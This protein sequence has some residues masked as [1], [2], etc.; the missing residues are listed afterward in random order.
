MILKDN[1]LYREW[2][3]PRVKQPVLQLVIPPSMKEDL[4]SQL[5]KQRWSGH[6]GIKRTLGRM[7]RCVYWAGYKADIHRLCR[8]CPECLRCKSP[9]KKPRHPLKKYAVGLHSERVGLDI[10][11]P[12]TESSLGNKYI[13]VVSDYFT[14]W[15][16]ACP[17]PN[18]EIVTI[19]NV[20]V[21]EFISRF[22]VQLLLHSDQR[23]QF[24]SSLF[25]ELCSLLDIDKT[26]TTT[27]HPQ[28]DGLVE[29]FNLTLENMLS[30]SIA[31]DLREWDSHLPM[32]MLAYRFSVH[33]S[34][35][36]TPA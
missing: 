28:S 5:H 19:A 10:L 32:L 31:S 18:Q 21:N 27:Y 33:E 1:V 16:E 35:G 13:L 30:K 26:R 3:D 14:K 8:E 22:G 23:S 12:L 17:M 2:F 29:R 6:L 25:Q 36:Q 11:G 7:G 4:F 24:E 9:D 34:T 15:V 20:L